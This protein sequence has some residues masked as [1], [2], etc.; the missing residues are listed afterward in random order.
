MT[1][2]SMGTEKYETGWHQI[3]QVRDKLH[4]RIEY[5]EGA[6]HF[7]K[8]IKENPTTTIIVKSYSGEIL[9]HVK[10]ISGVSILYTNGQL[11]EKNRD[12]YLQV[13]LEEESA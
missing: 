5:G 8:R 3:Q 1:T 11:G 10:K 13:E 6:K 2:I 9:I 7:L 12:H 4:L